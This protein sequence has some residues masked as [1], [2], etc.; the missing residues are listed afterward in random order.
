MADEDQMRFDFDS[1]SSDSLLAKQVIFPTT[2]YQGSKRQIVDWIWNHMEGL[3]FDSVLDLFAGTGAIAHKAKEHGKKTYFND[4]LQFNFQIGLAIVE[5]NE[6]TLTEDEVDWLL[7]KHDG[8]DYPTFIQDEFEGLYFTDEENEW[9]DMMQV[10]I[11]Q[12]DNKYK[13]AIAYSA[14]SQSCLAKR[15]YNLFHRANLYMRTEEVE[16]SFGNKTTW[17]K[18]FE[19]HFRKNVSEYNSA[20]FDN[21]R[22]NKA[23]NRDVMEWEDIPETDLVYIDPPYYDRTKQN[24]DT[25]YQFYYH[26]LEGF[27]QYNEWSDMI[28]H[29]VKTKRLNHEPSPWTDKDRIYTAF[30]K[31]F[32]KFQDSHIVLS[33]NS[34]GLPTPEELNDMLE[35]RKDNVIADAKEHQYAL[36]THEDSADEIIFVAYE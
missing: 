1:D 32:D 21:G 23:F 7:T 19:E 27:L 4:Y 17:D 28:D 24:G 2:R 20:V 22:E 35:E 5:N 14:L 15:P 36:S 8:F 31:V 18:S 12:L 3:E 9:L 25:N 11:K 33:Y 13:E 6:F 30:E 10:N 34:A 16:R 26:F 29:S